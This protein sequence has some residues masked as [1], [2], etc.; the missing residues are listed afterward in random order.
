MKISCRVISSEEEYRIARQIRTEVF[1]EEQKVAEEDEFDG[2][3]DVSKH[4]LAYVDGEAAAT[5]RITFFEDRTKLGR[6]AVLKDFRGLG[7]GMALMT[8]I[9]EIARVDGVR[10]V[11]G[12]A[13]THAVEFYER[14]GF[15]CEGGEFDEAGIPHIKMV[16]LK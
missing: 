12:H 11:Y 8:F 7:V 10:P 3:D 1:V 16:V 13:Q 5:A 9:I 2:L 6:V 14:L 4:V 15:E